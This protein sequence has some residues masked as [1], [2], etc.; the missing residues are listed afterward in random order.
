MGEYYHNQR[1]FP[2]PHLC[3][4]LV[5]YHLEL[6]DYL[7]APHK[8]KLFLPLYHLLIIPPLVHIS[9]I[10]GSVF[11][12]IPNTRFITLSACSNVIPVFLALAHVIEAVVIR[13]DAAS[14][15]V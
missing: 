9:T 7:I 5:E 15:I 6:V 14:S 11:L 3:I 12:Y 8:Y 2:T 4:L 10:P 13:D 1:F